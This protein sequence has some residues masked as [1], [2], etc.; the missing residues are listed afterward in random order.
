MSSA[1]KAAEWLSK[2]YDL[3]RN[4]VDEWVSRFEEASST[5]VEDAG[6]ESEETADEEY[7]IEAMNE[8]GLDLPADE[9]DEWNGEIWEFMRKAQNR[10]RREVL[11]DE[12]MIDGPVLDVVTM[13]K[14]GQTE[15]A[16]EEYLKEQYELDDE[17]IKETIEEAAEI[18]NDDESYETGYYE[19]NDE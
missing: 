18:F 6:L 17:K 7:I 15:E 19:N 12:E 13:F 11:G 16:A 3:Q 5:D 10:A 1:D 9:F 4:L 8:A 14:Q 2:Q